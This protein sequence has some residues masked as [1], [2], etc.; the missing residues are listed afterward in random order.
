MPI[1]KA[2]LAQNDVSEIGQLDHETIEKLP[3]GALKRALVRLRVNEPVCHESHFTN[4]GQH[5]SSV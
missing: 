3:T 1:E 2:D 5:S 4:H